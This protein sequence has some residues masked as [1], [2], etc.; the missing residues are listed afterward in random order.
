MMKSIKSQ[1][2]ILI[3]AAV[4]PA[5][6]I[7]IY[8]N[9]ER[10]SHEIDMAKDNALIMLQGLANDHENDIEVTRKFLMT[11][12]K[13]P[14]LRNQNAAACTELF[15]ELLKDNTQYAT[16]FAADSK[17]MLFANALPSGNISIKQRKY[18][19]NVLRTKDFSAG[20]YIIGPVSRRPGL[21]FAYPV[22]DYSGRVIGVVGIS[23]DLEKYG[24]NFT[25]ITQFPKG[26]TLNLL[27]R[28]FIRL[29]RYPEQGKYVGEADLPEIAR[30]LLS[31][32][33]QG[34]FTSIGVDGI[35]RLFAYKRFS[36]RDCSS[37]YLY[38]RVGIP[39]EHTLAQA[40]KTFLRHIVVL[41][42]CLIAT[43]LVALFL[44]N[45]LI[46]KRLNRLIDAFRHVGHGDFT[47]RTGVDHK[48][49]ELGKLAHSFDEMA[50]AL[51]T[52]ELE[53]KQAEE[54]LRQSEVFLNTLLNSIPI[55]VFYKGRDGRYTGF[56]RAFETFFGA[57]K[58]QMIGKTVFDINPP[59]LAKIYHTKDNELFEG[60]SE[61]HYETQVKNSLGVTRDVIFN[62]AVFTDSQ[63][64]VSGLI[65]AI[66]DITERKRADEEREKYISEL[67]QAMSKIKTLSGLLPICAS[68]KKI[69]DDKGYWNQIE[70]FI[71]DHSEAEFSHG[72]CPECA[73]KLYPDIFEKIQNKKD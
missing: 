72:I 43:L 69:R 48:G 7:I 58:E 42:S 59:E 61:Q 13:L 30:Q 12:A 6:G 35:K 62:K 4:L 18:F 14:A 17:G 34:L 10:Q 39:E 25:A 20:E 52:K 2:L 65:G 5:F 41:I 3:F 27:D 53:R 73:K 60:G 21:P 15:R 16:I 31:G 22:M 9:Y 29:Y 50:E 38:M 33:Q 67:Q 11:L 19:Q 36:L 45:V 1:L 51:E 70:S 40:K 37:P 23:L 68:C 55:P 24:R 56:N 46:V 54:A 71:R 47:V 26:S 63:G 57:T 64:T 8:S 44:G 66:L 32:P 28:N 49:G